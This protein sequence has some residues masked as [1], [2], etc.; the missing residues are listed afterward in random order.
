MNFESNVKG[1]IKKDIDG[2]RGFFE[3]FKE[4][5]ISSL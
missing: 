4:L 1:G 2:I 5:D 3:R